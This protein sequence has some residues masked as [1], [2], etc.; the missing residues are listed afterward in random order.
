MLHSQQALKFVQSAQAGAGSPAG[1][2]TQ[3]EE[4]VVEFAGSLWDLLKLCHNVE[5]AT[6]IDLGEATV[7]GIAHAEVCSSCQV[8]TIVPQ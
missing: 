6:T 3:D 1:Q 5:A 4:K 8:V 7:E 2:L